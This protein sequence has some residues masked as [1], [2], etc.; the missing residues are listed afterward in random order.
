MTNTVYVIGAGASAEAKLPT[1][2]ELKDEI[3]RLLNIKFDTFG[4]KL[5]SGDYIIVDALRKFVR[6]GSDG[7][8]SISPLIHNCRAISNGLSTAIS[9]DNFLDNH[10]DNPEIALCGKLGIV[11]AILQAERKS[12]LYSD[13]SA[14][15]I[16]FSHVKKSWYVYFVQLLT[17]NCDKEDLRDRLKKIT[18]IIFNYDR[19]VERYLY[20]ALMNTY[21]I[22]P[23]EANELLGL[24]TIY[25]PY[26]TISGSNQSQS[27]EF[28]GEPNA[29][30]L[31]DFAASIK[32][33][34]ES[35][36]PEES[37][38]HALRVQMAQAERLVFL[39]FAFHKI[40]MELIRP[41]NSREL[42]ESIIDCYATGHGVSDSDC[43]V[44]EEHLKSLFDRDIKIRIFNDTCA[45]L[46][47]EFKRCLA[48]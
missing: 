39:G 38:I 19:C 48:F 24:I 42:G 36:D 5:T 25:H 26:G 32:T 8:T 47:G 1:G 22:D 4:G 27:I 12:L 41:D 9:I 3:A 13:P 14:R 15:Q 45:S 44:I 10:R 40:N 28:G 16:N 43:E 17:E 6:N 29:T 34:T 30:Q 46:F 21:R 31:L 18:L 33:F 37:D 35:V 2:L 23:E 11:R 20:F 7:N